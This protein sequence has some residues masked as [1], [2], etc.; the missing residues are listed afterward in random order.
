[1]TEQEKARQE[2]ETQFFSM[3]GIIAS[4][5]GLELKIDPDTRNIDLIGNADRR[6][7]VACAIEIGNLAKSYKDIVR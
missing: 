6:E 7:I 2:K 5:Y 1:M 4:K 3:C